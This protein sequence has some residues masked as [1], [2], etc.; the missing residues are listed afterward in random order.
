MLSIDV[1][2][3]ARDIEAA[4]RRSIGDLRRRGVVVGLSGG[5]D[6][7][8]VTCLTARALGPQRVQVLLMPERDSSPESLVLGR[9]LTSQLGTPTLVENIEPVLDAAGCYARQFEA[10]K[11]VFPNYGDGYRNKITLP[12]IL[13][14]GRLNVSELTISWSKIRIRTIASSL[15]VI[16][17]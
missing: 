7:S 1:E 16:C 8:V 2:K 14:N 4:I 5:I 12:S 11:A 10:I 6:S 15:N 17:R 13:E 9:L 3:T